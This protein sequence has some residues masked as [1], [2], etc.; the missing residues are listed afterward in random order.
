M[1]IYKSFFVISFISIYL[2]GICDNEILA[3]T[4]KSSKKQ[5]AKNKKKTSKNKR[6]LASSN[7][8]VKEAEEETVSDNSQETVENTNK[9][10]S[11]NL[12]IDTSPEAPAV[13]NVTETATVD[14]A[15]V[16][17]AASSSDGN[18]VIDEE[19]E[20]SILN[21]KTWKDFEFCMQ[22]QCM[23]GPEQPNNVECYKSI[24]LD[25][26][27][28]SCKPMITDSAKQKLFQNYFKEVFLVNEQKEA[29][30][31]LFSGKWDSSK[32]N[33]DI[34][35]SYV[36]KYKSNASFMKNDKV[37]CDDNVQKVYS[38]PTN[39]SSIKFTCNHNT[40]NLEECYADNEKL[41]ANQVGMI[42]GIAQTVVGAGTMV[43]AG[44]V[45]AGNVKGEEKEITDDKGKVT[46]TTHDKAT[47]SQ[48]AAA[49]FSE[50]LTSG[51]G[52]MMSGVGQ[53]AEAYYASKDT[54]AK[55]NGTCKLPDGTI[56]SEG[57]IVE[58]SW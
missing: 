55:V 43:A 14:A 8:T 32:K 35:V 49:F 12:V 1:K 21:D 33:C 48:K 53:I 13:T 7:T 2:F 29:C 31:E 54:G 3:A 46:G 22:Q 44:A 4:K 47:G 10:V 34:T 20:K 52:T 17:V 19:T 11:N 36:R 9:T 15:P 41:K 37:G 51:S 40:F 38:L 56:K 26:T 28:N 16:A 45:A 18:F 5:S 25:N 30:Q 6:S 58:L 42:M 23:G 50:G 39:G 57:S 27:F 24:N